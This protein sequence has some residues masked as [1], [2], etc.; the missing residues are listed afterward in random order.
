MKLL[1]AAGICAFT[2][3]VQAQQGLDTI[4]A[5]ISRNNKT[6]QTQSKYWDAQQLR[7]K[8]GIAL[9]DPVVS[10]DF[11][12]G[13]PYAVAGNQ[14]DFTVIQRFDFPTVYSKKRKLADEQGEQAGFSLVSGRQG[15]LLEAKMACIEL[16]YRNRL[17]QTIEER[18]IK[19][20]KFLADFKKKLE[21]G[22]IGRAWCR[23][24][25]CQ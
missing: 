17:H 4:L 1:M 25:V 13:T 9:Y 22:E 7:Y 14:T 5:D 12:R 3:Q 20:E 8:T 15:I 16:V 2:I 10:Y 18:K 21:N 19:T 24:R 6:L 11:M 23:E